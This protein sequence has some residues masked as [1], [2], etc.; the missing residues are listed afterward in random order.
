MAPVKKGSSQQEKQIRLLEWFQS[1]HSFYTLREIEQKAGKQCKIA[2]MQI[3]ELISALVND[4]LLQQEKCG[5]TNIYWSFRYTRFKEYSD[6]LDRLKREYTSKQLE[7][8]S[9]NEQITVAVKER[10]IIPN[11]EDL[12]RRIKQYQSVIQGIEANVALARQVTMSESIKSSIEFYTECL[13]A[14]LGYFSNLT[15]ISQTEWRKELGI[16]P[17]FEE[18]P[19]FAE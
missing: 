2:P 4:G 14:A 9:L 3:K 18:V 10:S 12:L 19:K 11:R 8:S 16:P 15:G 17:D 6:N 1:E 5:V 13:E 7:L